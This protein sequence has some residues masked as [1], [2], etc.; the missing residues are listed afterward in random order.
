MLLIH[1]VSA[2]SMPQMYGR[3]SVAWLDGLL[4]LYVIKMLED[5]AFKLVHV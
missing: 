2:H 3:C 1:H 4:S 5:E